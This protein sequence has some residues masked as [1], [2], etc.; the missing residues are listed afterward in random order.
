MIIRHIVGTG[1]WGCIFNIIVPRHMFC[2]HGDLVG[3]VLREQICGGQTRHAS[4]VTYVS[5]GSNPV[6]AGVKLE[7]VGARGSYPR[8]TMLFVIMDSLTSLKF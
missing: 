5:G 3:G 7:K 8:T 1:P 2:Q 6:P 4:A